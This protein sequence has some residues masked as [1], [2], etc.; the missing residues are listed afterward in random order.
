MSGVVPK[1]SAASGSAPC[2]S[3]SFAIETMSPAT[4]PGEG[5]SSASR[6]R[7]RIALLMAAGSLPTIVKRVVSEVT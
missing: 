3:S 4:P 5:V 2:S 6:E 7:L 1:T